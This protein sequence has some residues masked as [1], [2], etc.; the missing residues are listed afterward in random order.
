MTK[1]KDDSAEQNSKI[2]EIQEK[3]NETEKPEETDVQKDEDECEQKVQSLENQLK[4]ALADYQNL[5]K[6]VQE[7]RVN[8]IRTANKDIILRLLP[9][10]DTLMLARQH[11]QDQGLELSIKQF[12]Q[13][14]KDEGIEKIETEGEE[15]DPYTM[16]CIQTIEGKEG[17]VLEEI[18]TGY[19]I[20]EKVIRPAQVKVGQKAQ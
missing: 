10:L 11:V 13:V 15:F 20:E 18:R 9:V 17:K 16:E 19:T 7:E 4:R 14:L 2:E 3:T 6:R 12:I 5:Q 1:K 8:W